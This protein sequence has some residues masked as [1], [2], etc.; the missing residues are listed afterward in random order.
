MNLNYTEIGITGAG[1]MGTAI[2]ESI[3]NAG[4]DKKKIY[5]SR[6]AIGHLI[7]I[8]RKYNTIIDI[9]RKDAQLSTQKI[10]RK[11]G[12]PITTVHNRIK[13]LK[14]ENIIKKYTVEIDPNAVDKGFSAYIL[15]SVNL[16]LM[17]DAKKT[18]YDLAKEISRF[19]FVEKVDI[20]S[21]GIDLVAHIRTKDVSTFDKLLLNE[22]QLL[23]GINN[24]QSLIVLHEF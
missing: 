23:E 24:T 16:Q 14:S 15:I 4:H 11:T 13:K 22:L 10:S 2:L 12:I 5:V 6:R 8:E 20:V 1:N 18:Q 9:L 17:K 19:S 3:I 21:G 7:E